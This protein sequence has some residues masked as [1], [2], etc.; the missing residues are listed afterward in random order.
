MQGH[1]TW[2]ALS[3]RA[4]SCFRVMLIRAACRRAVSGPA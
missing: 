2:P 1:W 3:G 4:A